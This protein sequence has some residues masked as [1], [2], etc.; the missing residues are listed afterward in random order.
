MRPGLRPRPLRRRRGA[1][2]SAGTCAGCS[3]R[4][5]AGRRRRACPRLSLLAE[6]S[7]A[8]AARVERPRPP[9]ARRRGLSPTLFE[10]QAAAHAGRRSRWSSRTA[11]AHLRASSNARANRLAHHL[12][13]RGRRPGVAG[14]RSACERS[15]TWWSALLGVLK[16]GGAYLP[17]DPAYPAERLAFMLADA[18][19]ALL[20]TDAAAE[21]LR[22]PQ[23][24][25]RWSAVTSPA[26][27]PSAPSATAQ[28][29]AAGPTT[30]PTSSTPPARPAGPRACWSPTA[31]CPPVRAPRTPGSASARTTSGRCSTPTPSTSR[32]GRSGARCST[33]AGWWSCPTGEPLARGVPRAAGARAG[34]GAQPDAVGV[35]PARCRPTRSDGRA[36]RARAALRHL[37]RRGARPRRACAPWFERHGDDAAAAGQHVRHHR[38]HRARHLPAA[39]R[40]GRCDAARRQR[41]SACRSRTCRSTCSTAHC[42]PVPVGVPGEM[43]VGG[44]GL[45]RGYL[46]R[47]ELTAERFVPDPFGARPGAR[48]Y[49][50][51]DLARWRAGRRRSSTSAASTTR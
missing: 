42:S 35:P 29:A 16:A 12:R 39:D 20:L 41:R 19:A 49:R 24:R 14:R 23:P 51:G 32:S 30:S 37:R 46:G 48:L 13:G 40:G 25:L 21:R 10:A 18:G 8:A 36:R 47:P 33:A 50:S 38:D 22:R 5:P 1:P 26:A 2:R 34:D 11:D 17:L 27:C 31:T 43:Y 7:G 4:S 28:P 6:P 45:A 9:A 15:S 44:A 3:R